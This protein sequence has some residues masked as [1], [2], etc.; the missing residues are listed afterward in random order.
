MICLAVGDSIA[1][2]V[3]QVLGCLIYAKVGL[4]S[5]EITRI[6]TPPA[7]LCIVSAG[8]N[9]PKNPKLF[10]NLNKIGMNANSSCS[11]VV[12]VIPVDENA[13]LQVRRQSNIWRNKTVTFKPDTD[14]V[15]PQSYQHL[16]GA[17][18]ESL[19]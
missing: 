17:I 15:H 8:S 7:D 3:G 4:S 5:T 10:D 9:D 1:Y 16:G 11:T 12:W 6:Q 2:G 18:L 14:G 13:A 19:R